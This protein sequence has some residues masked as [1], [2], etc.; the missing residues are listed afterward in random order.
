MIHVALLRG[1][2][3]GGKNKVNMKVLKQSFERVGMKA[4]VTY[5]NTGNIIFT[6]DSLSKAEISHILEEVIQ[7]DFGLSI[8]VLVRSLDDFSMIMDSLPESWKNDQHM[9]SD[10][11]F[12]WDD[13]DDESVLGK[14][15]IKPEID[16]VQYVPGA[17]LW[18]IDRKNVTK[19]G[20]TK[21]VGTNLYKKM[22]VRNV[23]TTRKIYELM[24]TT[25]S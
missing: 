12:L 16:T 22:T 5:I 15:V 20:M 9:K 25:H 11:M 2:N 17:V 13:V 6:N 19:S 10:V 18:S 3:V 14:L 23:N 1:I 21:L 4:V 24:L 8:K 7:E